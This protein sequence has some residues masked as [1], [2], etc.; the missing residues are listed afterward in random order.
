VSFH[1]TRRGVQIGLGLI[2]LLDG[3]LQFQSF[4]F[5][6]SFLTGM[7]APLALGQP[8]PIA[9]SIT[10][11]AGVASHHL[12]QYDTLFGF[13]QVLIG[14]G[15]LFPP[16]VRPAL[17]LSF[18]WVPIVWWFGEGLG[19]IPAGMA[20]PLTGAPGAVLLYGLIGVC[21]WPKRRPRVSAADG[22][23]VGDRGGLAFWSLLWLLAAALWL[24]GV[25]RAAGAFQSTIASQEP[26]SM[27]WLA[28][29]Q[30][31]V[32]KATNGDGL[33]LAVLLALLSVAVAVGVWTPLRTPALWL[34]I[35][36][37][38]AYWLFGQGM[39]DLTTTQA[40]DV[41]AGPVFILFALALLPWGSGRRL[42]ATDNERRLLEEPPL[43][44][45]A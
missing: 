6:Q 29:L 41:N 1:V 32:A 14:L 13:I 22:G 20:S 5:S 44:T 8:R 33:A 7:I 42:P 30:S 23:L 19:M 27:G 9:H 4:F 31:S 40:T 17:V 39:G 24:Q 25:N 12:I 16:T 18:V 38:L 34:G 45:G 37:S 28:S 26:S 2:W 11:A 10:W 3:V 21:V 15:L 36:L 35:V 43:P